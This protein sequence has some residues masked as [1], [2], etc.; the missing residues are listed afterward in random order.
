[1]STQ[2]VESCPC[3][4]CASERSSRDRRLHRGDGRWIDLDDLRRD[5]AAEVKAKA[6]AAG[7]EGVR[8]S[9]RIENP[10][11]RGGRVVDVSLALVRK[12]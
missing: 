8:V 1:M 2:H 3:I 11:K 6:I 7:L 5:I 10:D 12:R 4:A 9:V